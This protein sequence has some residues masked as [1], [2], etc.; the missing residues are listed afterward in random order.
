M[1]FEIGPLYIVINVNVIFSQK[2]GNFAEFPLNSLSNS[3]DSCMNIGLATIGIP[4]AKL[5][6][7]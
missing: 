3:K 4:A 6:E 7:G 5:G 2:T 1:V